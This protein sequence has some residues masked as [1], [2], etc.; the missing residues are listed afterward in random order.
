MSLMRDYIEA[1]DHVHVCNILPRQ[2]IYE[3]PRV[4]DGIDFVVS[5]L[6]SPLVFLDMCWV[7][8]RCNFLYVM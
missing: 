3:V 7:G 2:P 4:L 6:S 1:H 8:L 5:S